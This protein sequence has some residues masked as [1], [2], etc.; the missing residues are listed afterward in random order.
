MGYEIS[1]EERERRRQRA[2]QL[3]EEGKIGPQFGKL[4]GRPR[5]PRVSEILAEEARKDADQML[6]VLKDGIRS[7]SEKTALAYLQT[8][9]GL[10]HD[11]AKLRLAEEKQEFDIGQAS[12]DELIKFLAA[13]LS[14][15]PL[16]DQIGQVID[17]TAEDIGDTGELG[18]EQSEVD[19][20]SSEAS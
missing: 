20:G 5:K 19:G 10:E 18:H 14:E 11:E 6:K 12:R 8:W 3:K 7:D 16:A 2:L 17:G 13:S 4:G 15:G 1:D 9:V